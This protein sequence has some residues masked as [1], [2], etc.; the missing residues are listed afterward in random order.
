M[1][2]S[3]PVP[4]DRSR[5]TGRL[6]IYALLD[7]VWVFAAIQRDDVVGANVL[8]TLHRTLPRKVRSRIKQGYLRIREAGG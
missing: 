1:G 2:L 8:T 5:R 7:G 3:G 6:E 4:E